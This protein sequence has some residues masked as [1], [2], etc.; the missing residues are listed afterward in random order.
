MEISIKEI[1]IEGTLSIQA[2]DNP[3]ILQQKL[4]SY[5][6]SVVRRK[7]NE[8]IGR[9]DEAPQLSSMCSKDSGMG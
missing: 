8:Q 7:I 2:G 6:P 3:R 5:F 1:V 4:T 9:I